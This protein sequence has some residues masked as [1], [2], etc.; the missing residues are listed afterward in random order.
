MNRFWDKVTKLE[1]ECWLWTAKT[2][3]AGYGRFWLDGHE[4]PAHR[5]AYELVNAPVPNGLQLDHLC[6]NPTCVNPAHLEPVTPAENLA[7]R[8][9]RNQYRDAT[10]CIHGHPFAGENLYIS[11]RGKRYCKTCRRATDRRRPDRVHA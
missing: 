11:P 1:G 3:A 10:H 5:V 6:R 7:R 4:V 2:D 8:R 9:T